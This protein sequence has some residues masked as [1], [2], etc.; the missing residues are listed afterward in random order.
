VPMQRRSVVLFA[1]LAALA[2]VVAAMTTVVPA[3]QAAPSVTLAPGF[4]PYSHLGEGGTLSTE[5][6]FTGNE[7]HGH[8]APLTSLTLHLPAGTGL[9]SAGFP[10]CSKETVESGFWWEDCPLGSVAGPAGSL[11][12]LVTFGSEPVREEATVQ[13]IFGPAGVL[14]F[15]VEGHA[16]VGLE[17]IMEGHFAADSSPYADEALVLQ[18]P[19]VELVPGYPD[20]SVTSLTLNLGA[21]REEGGTEINSVTVP[22][23]CPLS[24]TFPW[25][26]DAGFNSEPSARV[27]ETES[28]CPAAGTRSK[29]TTTLSVSNTAPHENEP[30]TYTA[31]VRP[32]SASGPAP[33]GTVTFDDGLL[34]IPG[35]TAQPLTPGATA[36]TATCQ[37]S[38]SDPFTHKI[39]ATYSGNESY[40]G[41]TSP[42]ETITVLEGPALK[43][44]PHETAKEPPH[45]AATTS[46]NGVPAP[47]S[48]PSP[49]TI[50]RT[51][52]AA[53][54]KQ[55]LVPKGKALSIV[56]LLAHRGVRLPFAAPTAGKLSVQ[57]YELPAGA[58]LARHH[59]QPVLVASGE[60]TFTAASKAT[61][62]I[63]LT[64]AGK[65]LLKHA[66]RV[67]LA[68]RGQ[69]VTSGTSVNAVR[70][71]VLTQ[72]G[73]RQ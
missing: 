44:E 18:V 42:T 71:F 46:P 10:T 20:M 69:F 39:R 24:G 48:P 63:R 37:A 56:A 31:T 43:E 36:A 57:W 34:P 66:K 25:A 15:V 28:G 22:G 23:E 62:R 3:A 2:S 33:Y 58:H 13:A 61:V 53:S 52:I 64:A 7:Y 5:L 68:L 14:Y 51:Q 65:R 35:C 4:S 30:V 32:T 47:T 45:E 16:P 6:T 27:A 19:L 11:T 26:A 67:K 59:V 54:L 72:R 38:Y 40:R 17:F 1:R 29:T 9:T 60:Q 12:A 41:S 55:Q 73:G 70:T 50:S 49:A 21:T 8:V